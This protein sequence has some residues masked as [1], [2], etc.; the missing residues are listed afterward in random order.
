MKSTFP[1]QKRL[2]TPRVKRL[3]LLAFSAVIA[4]SLYALYLGVQALAALLHTSTWLA[5]GLLLLTVQVP[6]TTGYGQERTLALLPWYPAR[7]AAMATGSGLALWFYGAQG[8]WFEV[9]LLTATSLFGL[10]LQRYTR[11][12]KASALRQANTGNNATHASRRSAPAI[13]IPTI[14][15]PCP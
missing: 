14:P 9:C 6:Y 12:L 8:R 11:Y 10:A 7:L 5:A 15:R 2:L 3:L 13:G 4:V 1:E